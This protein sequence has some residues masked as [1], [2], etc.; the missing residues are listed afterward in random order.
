MKDEDGEGTLA[1]KD[2]GLK[3]SSS[4][5]PMSLAIL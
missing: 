4:T 1:T 3:Q 5:F 2:E